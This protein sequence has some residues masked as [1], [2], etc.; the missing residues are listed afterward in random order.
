[1]RNLLFTIILFL[2]SIQ[3]SH[4]QTW[5]AVNS[6]GGYNMF[7]SIV[8]N[9]ELYVGGQ[10]LILN[11]GFSAGSS[12]LKYNGNQWDSIGAFQYNITRCFAEYNGEL[13]AGGRFILMDGTPAWIVRLQGNNWVP[14]DFGLT[15]QP[16]ALCVY[17]GELYEAETMY[18]WAGSDSIIQLNKWDGQQWTNMFTIP[19][20]CGGNWI[21]TLA[22]YQNELYI[23]GSFSNICGT[24]SNSIIKYNGSA[25]TD[26][27]GTG[28][29]LCTSVSDLYVLHDTLFMTGN[30]NSVNNIAV[31]K[32]AGWTGSS[33][34]AFGN[35]P[36][37]NMG[38]K[39]YH[40]NDKLILA[41]GFLQGNTAPSRI[42]EWDGSQWTVI[43]DTFPNSVGST[44]IEYNNELY[45]GGSL[46][47]VHDFQLL[48]KLATTT[49]ISEYSENDHFAIT[50]PV[51]DN[52]YIRSPDFEKN[53]TLSIYDMN[54]KCVKANINMSSSDNINVSFLNP[55]MYI[56]GIIGENKEYYK[57]FIKVE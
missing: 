7:S 32:I 38:I 50:N 19:S 51:V 5:Q 28:L 21:S 45:A 29:P 25:F 18:N 26:V 41:E 44:L 17:N 24:I 15:R 46:Y 37:R 36:L 12:I 31:N 30:F 57:R 47:G 33:W 6:A 11:G 3:V 34:F 8:F 49:G 40:R 22:V 52:L 54:G 53:I 1:M 55:G 23:G 2:F 16:N 4:A 10:A 43:S 27:G 48:I 14:V 35:N 9:G 39:L 20:N 56:L 13:Y 42:V